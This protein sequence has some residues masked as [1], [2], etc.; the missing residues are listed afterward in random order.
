MST[1]QRDALIDV[2]DRV[3]AIAS[4]VGIPTALIGAMALA[5]HNYVRGTADIDIATS[6][7]PFREL[8]LLRQ[9]LDAEGLQTELI[10]PDANDT[11]GGILRV[12]E[13][14]AD[15]RIVIVNF[16]N[17]LR[18]IGNPG[19]EAIQ[20]AAPLAPL[21]SLRCATLGHLI[22][23]KLFAGSRRDQADVIELLRRNPAT[24]RGLLR[25]VC[26]GYGYGEGLE[27]LIRE[28]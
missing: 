11:L 14:N 3:A 25:S 28:V 17:P 7:D 23:L 1:G 13:H 26:A 12:R 2:A 15:D 22:A 9:R 8:R 24:D 18:P 19:L 16:Y 20:S 21:S 4:E 6:V 5:V 27:E 10:P